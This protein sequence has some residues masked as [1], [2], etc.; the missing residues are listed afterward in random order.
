M[1]RG[2]REEPAEKG[3]S[4]GPRDQAQSGARRADNQRVRK[5]AEEDQAAV[6]RMVNAQAAEIEARAALLRAQAEAAVRAAVVVQPVAAAAQPRNAAVTITSKPSALGPK[7]ELTLP[8]VRATKAEMAP[9]A[10]PA[11]PAPASVTSVPVDPKSP[12]A[13]PVGE[14]SEADKLALVS[15]GCWP[16]TPVERRGAFWTRDSDWPAEWTLTG[17]D[18]GR[19]RG[20]INVTRA[21][22][23][24]Q[25]G[26]GTALLRDAETSPREKV[27]PALQLALR[28][29]M[30]VVREQRRRERDERRARAEAAPAPAF[31]I[32]AGGAQSPA[33]AS[34][35]AL[36]TPAA[37]VVGAAPVT[38]FTGADLNR[39]RTERGLS[40]RE[41]AVLM[42]VGHG[43]V[44]KAELVPTKALG[45]RMLA[46]FAGVAL[47]G[48]APG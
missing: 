7:I 28:R 6:T 12:R 46:A 23:A 43:M 31:A 27:R 41:L 32:A 14:F 36:A 1:E 15:V 25:L 5:A 30:N 42:G 4:V 38:V 11:R 40:Q 26:V 24:A 19:F 33:P 37:Q 47:P 35:P 8:I 18:L 10:A 34:T 13:A 3:R 29:A 16:P 21:V 20:E 22:F 39:F 2:N 44:G 45:E 9:V 17:G 48:G